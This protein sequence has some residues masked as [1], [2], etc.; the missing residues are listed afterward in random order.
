VTSRWWR[1]LLVAVV[2]PFAVSGCTAPAA[3]VIPVGPTRTD[4]YQGVWLS[5]PYTMPAAGLRAT[6]GEAFDLRTGSSKPVQ[7][8]FFGYTSCPDVCR[9]T[10]ADLATALNRV[11]PDVR[12]RVQVVVITVDPGRD[13]P[14]VLRS[15]LDRFDPE[16][17][18]LT[19]TLSEIREIGLS[20]GV[21]VEGT[22]S[23]GGGYEVLHSTQVIGFDAERRGRLVWTQGTSIAT[24]KADLERFAAAQP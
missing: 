15:Y 3:Q 5:Q 9:T 7:I 6:S 10:L 20:M 14:E 17:V 19:G 21:V 24:Y 22:K 1:A 11:T 4:G 12:A 8:I 13:T 23:V 18:G 2:V 16:F